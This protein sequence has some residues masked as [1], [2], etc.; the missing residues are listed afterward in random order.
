MMRMTAHNNQPLPKP[1]QRQVWVEFSR[2]NL[3]VGLSV[4]APERGE[5]PC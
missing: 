5:K 3:A 1:Q 2:L 4:P